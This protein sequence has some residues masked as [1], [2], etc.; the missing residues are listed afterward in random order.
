MLFS[1]IDGFFWGKF[2]IVFK[3][4]DPQKCFDNIMS[5]DAFEKIVN[6]LGS[7][8]FLTGNEVRYVDLYMYEVINFILALD[9]T[10]NQLYTQFPSLKAYYERVKAVPKFAAYLNSDKYQERLYAPPFTA[11]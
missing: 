8:T 4:A 10:G 2:L 7:K 6:Y 11:C 9:S 5:G 1:V 3:E